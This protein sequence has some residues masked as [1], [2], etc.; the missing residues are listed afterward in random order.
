MAPFGLRSA[1]ALCSLGGAVGETI[2]RSEIEASSSANPIRRVVSMLQMMEQKI[3]EEG[4]KEKDLFDKFQCYCKTGTS[5]LSASISAAEAKITQDTSSLEQATAQKAQLEQELEAHK[6]DRVDAKEALAKASALREKE[7]AVYAK[8]SAEH[9]TNVAALSKAIAALD[10]GMTGFLQTSTGARLRQMTIDMDLSAADRDMLSAFLSTGAS[11]EYAPRSGQISGILKEMKDTMEKDL[12]E[13]T[14]AEEASIKDFEELS[15]AKTK[16]IEVNGAAIETKTGRHGQLGLE[17]VA[18]KEDLDDTSKALLDDRSFLKDLDKNCATKQQEWEERSA[19]RAEELVALSETI[20]LLND[21]EALELFKKTL[22]SPALLQTEG[23]MRTVCHR[24]IDTLKALRDSSTGRG[25]PRLD[26][27]MLALKGRSKNFDKVLKMIDDMVSLLGREQADDD[28]KKVYCEGA[29]DKTEDEKKALEQQ[30]EDHEKS[31]ADAKEGIA[32]LTE[33]LAA[34]AAGIKALDKA[35]VEATETRQAE[36]AEYKETMAANK[37]AKELLGVA[38]NRLA[39]FYTPKLYKSA[40]KRELSAEDRI[41]VNNGGTAPPT[42]APGGIANTGISPVLA[43]VAAHVARRSAGLVAPPPPPE[44]WDAYGKKG[45]EHS[46]VVAMLDMLV[47]DLDK[48]MTEADVEEKDSQKEYESFMEDS[49]TKRSAD[50][51]LIAE[52]EGHK[53]QLETT[54][55]KT[56]QEHKDAMKQAMGKAEQLRDL[57]LECDWLMSNFDARKEARA[58]EVESLKKAKAVLSGADFAFV[59]K[60]V[61]RRSQ[62]RGAIAERSRAA[63]L[64]GSGSLFSAAEAT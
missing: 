57:H 17:I 7:A 8:H 10:K 22:P 29:L 49:K 64:C 27:V 55:Q 39:K 45:Q 46:G 28:S 35:V 34:L 43:Q 59:Q 25:D 52:K 2:A 37:A 63:D 5:D 18:L 51:K 15:A 1:L 4:K 36:N 40:P 42:Q 30:I 11:A 14:S 56:S 32:T 47:A 62:L 54:L 9:K 3:Q 20:K 33:E 24:A 12:A 21:D 61:A 50:A 31:M 48:Q 23:S 41:F 16:E 38:K 6:Q 19:T 53:A 60:T 26:L 44:T 58:G 13:M